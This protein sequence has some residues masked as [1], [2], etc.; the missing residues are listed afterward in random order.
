MLDNIKNEIDI[1][2]GTFPDD[3]SEFLPLFDKNVLHFLEYISSKIFK[4]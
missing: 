3:K 4:N 1:V 2:A